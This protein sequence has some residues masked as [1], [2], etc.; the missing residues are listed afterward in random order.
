[1]YGRTVSRTRDRFRHLEDVSVCGVCGVVYVTV[2]PRKE[3]LSYI[4]TTRRKCKSYGASGIHVKE[5]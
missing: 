3:Y 1:M 2:P 4:E 5:K